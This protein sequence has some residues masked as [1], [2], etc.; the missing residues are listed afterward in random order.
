MEARVRYDLEY[1]RNWS[2][3]LDLKILFK[4]AVIVLND[5]RAY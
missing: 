4:T 5:A 2:I 1:V 3:L